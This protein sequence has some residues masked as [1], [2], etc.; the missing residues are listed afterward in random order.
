MNLH[1]SNLFEKN[2]SQAIDENN[3]ASDTHGKISIKKKK[4]HPHPYGCDRL[5]IETARGSRSQFRFLLCIA[6][7]LS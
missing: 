6:K 3:K 1:T 7:Q 4:R 5:V 2:C